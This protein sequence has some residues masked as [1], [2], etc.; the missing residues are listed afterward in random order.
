MFPKILGVVFV[1]IGCGLAFSILF[2]LIGSILGLSWLLIK[3]LIPIVL[4]Y[5]GYRFLKHGSEF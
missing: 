4:I 5:A 3:L 1:G 2:D